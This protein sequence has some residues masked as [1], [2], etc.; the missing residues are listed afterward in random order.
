M[1][2]RKEPNGRRSV[3]VEVAEESDIKVRMHGNVAVVTGGYH[4]TGTAKSKRYEYRDR[5][6]DIWLKTEGQWLLIAAHYS[7]PVQQ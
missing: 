4:E 3:Q 7:V 2:V 6:T 1:S 5:F